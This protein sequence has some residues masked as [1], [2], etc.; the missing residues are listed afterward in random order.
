LSKS[1]SCFPE[2]IIQIEVLFNASETIIVYSF[3]Q[4]ASKQLKELLKFSKV[5]KNSFAF[6]IIETYREGDKRIVGKT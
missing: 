4:L 5:L 3:S 6:G 2:S 1:C